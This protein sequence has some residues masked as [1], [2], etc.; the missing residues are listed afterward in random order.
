MNKVAII[1]VGHSKFG[2]R[3]DVNLSEL[4]FESIRESLNDA[5][6]TQKDI[7]FVGVGTAGGWYEESLPAIVIKYLQK[8]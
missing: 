4:A 6:I 2:N 5:N 8:Q 7:D 1:G 3:T